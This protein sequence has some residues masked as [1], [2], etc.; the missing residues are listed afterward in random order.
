MKNIPVKL[1]L[2]ILLPLLICFTFA[3]LFEKSILNQ[4][5]RNDL[6]KSKYENISHNEKASSERFDL[7][8][9]LISRVEVFQQ[10]EIQARYGITHVLYDI[11][12]FSNRGIQLDYLEINGKDIIISGKVI[13]DEAAESFKS[14]LSSLANL[15]YISSEFTSRNNINYVKLVYFYNSKLI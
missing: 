11:S 7:L 13:S 14:H 8:S 3:Y 4:Q 12:I 1:L 6:L 15:T 9:K 2:S 10:K 5:Q